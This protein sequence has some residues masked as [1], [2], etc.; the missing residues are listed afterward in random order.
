MPEFTFISK[1][2]KHQVLRRAQR[3]VPVPDG[4]GGWVTSQQGI[5]YEFQPS[6]DRESGKLVGQLV[7]KAGQDVL[8][9]DHGGTLRAGE[10]FGVKRDAPAFLQ[11]H[12][13]FGEDFWLQ[14][15]EPGTVYPRPADWRANVRKA[16]VGLDEEALVEMINAERKSHSRVDLISEA[17]DALALV[18]QARAE[19]DAQVAQ[20][21]AE[22]AKAAEKPATKQKAETTA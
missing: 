2:T 10:E 14:G 20:A 6:L 1:Y 5:R 13:A 11:A 21:E 4:S 9:S 12:R 16:S 17:E 3:E 8:D 22:Q 19:I 18:R 7:V 15:H